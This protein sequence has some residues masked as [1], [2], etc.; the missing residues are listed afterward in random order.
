MTALYSPLH[1]VRCE[2]LERVLPT[3][4]EIEGRVCGAQEVLKGVG[5]TLKRKYCANADVRVIRERIHKLQV[6]IGL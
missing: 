6:W 1:K 2:V 5:V 3:C 4:E